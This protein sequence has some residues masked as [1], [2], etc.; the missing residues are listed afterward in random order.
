[1]LR[2][3]AAK[4]QAAIA[5]GWVTYVPGNTARPCR[6]YAVWSGM[7]ARC[8]PKHR[9]FVWYGARGIHVCDEWH[10]YSTFRAWAVTNGYRKGL[11][12]DRRDNDGNYEPLNC[13][14][15]SRAEQNRNKRQ[16]RSRPGLG[17]FGAAHPC[18]KPVIQISA[19]GSERRF[20]CAAEAGRVTGLSPAHIS[21]CCRMERKRHGGYRWRFDRRSLR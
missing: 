13:R 5:R 15:I 20:A 11:T 6:L 21:S 3:N 8:R 18:S 1:M 17:K 12:L 9:A 16:G 4:Q 19:D 14:W 10:D 7:R 2:S